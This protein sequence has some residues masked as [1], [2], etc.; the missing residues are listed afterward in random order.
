MRVDQH[1][2]ISQKKRA[3]L[4][5]LCGQL[6]EDDAVDPREFFRKKYRGQDAKAQ[7]LCRQVQET[8]SLVLSG[9]FDDEVLQALDVFSV[10]PAPTTRRLVVVV[11]PD[12]HLAPTITPEQILARI[13]RVAG[14]LRS[15]VA[16]SIARRKAPTLVFEVMWAAASKTESNA[17]S[18]S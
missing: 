10:Q 18:V 6:N 16:T 4:L 12:P 14:R 1:M 7:R 11:R 9:E 13:Q 5:A 15:E 17:D 3:E 8:I 2:P